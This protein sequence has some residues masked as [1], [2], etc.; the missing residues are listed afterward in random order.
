MVTRRA[1][2]VWLRNFAVYRS[3][4]KPS[5][6]GN[7]GE[8]LLYL[9]AMGFGIGAY[10]TDIKGMRYMEFIAPGLIVTSSMYSAVFECTFGS[11]TRMT[12]QRTYE[13]IISTPV[14]LQDLVAGEILWGMTK[15]V[16][17]AAV[18]IFIMT[19]FGLYT[20]SVSIV[21][22]MVTVA[23]TGLV[24][25]GGAMCFSA[26]APS[27]E[28]FN[29]FFTL[30]IA[31]MFFLSGVFFPLDPFPPAVQWLSLAMPAT[32]SVNLI[33]HFFHGGDGN[34][35]LMAAL[36]LVTATAVFGVL[37]ERLV[38]RRIIV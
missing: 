20:P 5:L 34:G 14:S 16:I 31:P 13:S 10:I 26:L 36:F 30:F 12:I 11:Y 21:G 7:L 19:L 3:Y 8:P 9:F 17:S 18:M 32:H 25:A 27:Y 35:L 23:F 22:I 29:Y 15:S 24:F 1:F 6:V 33:R 38:R 2:H 28:F 4:Y 37:A